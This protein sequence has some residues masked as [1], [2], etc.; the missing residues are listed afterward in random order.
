[1]TQTPIAGFDA[2][3]SEPR[4]AASGPSNPRPIRRFTPVFDELRIECPPQ[5][6]MAIHPAYA[7]VSALL[8]AVFFLII[9]NGAVEHSGSR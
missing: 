1:M 5:P 2:G 4:Y 3:C 7:Q 6:P 9:G 8:T